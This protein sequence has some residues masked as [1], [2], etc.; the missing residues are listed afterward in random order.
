MNMDYNRNSRYFQKPKYGFSIF[1]I[2]VGIGVFIGANLVHAG[3]V[4]YLISIALIGL[5]VLL[6]AKTG[7]NRPT[8][9]EIDAQ[10]NA[11]FNS[12]FEKALEKHGLAADQVQK[13]PHVILGGYM[14]EEALANEA[15]ANAAVK[16]VLDAATSAKT[17]SGVLENVNR[18]TDEAQGSLSGIVYIRGKDKVLRASV[19]SWTV[20]LFSD[21]QVFTYTRLF[22]LVSPDVKEAGNE[23]FYQ[24]IVSIST[25]EISQG[26]IFQMKLSDGSEIIIP[27][28]TENDTDTVQCSITALK[29]MVREIKSK[30]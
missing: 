15:A 4:P 10:V 24:D 27:Y 16:N 12:L 28:S 3:A 23:Y 21:S 18:A 17:F 25:D 20:F 8:D 13:I 14:I 30:Q 6:I 11:D 19:V 5:A 26:H 7:G 22:S 9:A 29:Q 1:L 2:I